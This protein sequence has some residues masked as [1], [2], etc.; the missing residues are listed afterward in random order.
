MGILFESFEGNKLKRFLKR[1]DLSLT[2]LIVMDILMIL[3]S[4]L[5]NLQ[6]TYVDFILVFDSIVCIILI[7]TFLFKLSKSDNRNQFLSENW[8]DLIASLPL[9]LL[10]L[11]FPNELLYS[12]HFIILLRFLRVVLL[13]KN[14][15]KY[16]E[17]FLNAT[18]LDKI[19]AIFI[20]II[21]SSAFALIYFDS[22]VN[23]IYEAL[24]YIFQ[25]ITTVGYGDTIPESTVGRFIGLVLLVVGVVMFSVVTA[26]FGY[27]FNEKVF[28]EENEEFNN[29]ISMLKENAIE[30]RDSINEIKQKA[31]S[32]DANLERINERLDNLEENV[33]N[34]AA[35]M[36]EL[37]EIIGKK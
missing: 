22:N 35:R 8:L 20:V 33:N 28:K 9:G 23:N 12:Y 6:K 24:W 30:T 16:V 15:S 27:I 36:D 26:S 31:V 29:K 18:Y 21:V 5:F 32:N 13:F 10:I 17:N 25:T 2:I 1:M 7:I 19:I 14:I 37:I 4:I 34:M 11:P 3:V